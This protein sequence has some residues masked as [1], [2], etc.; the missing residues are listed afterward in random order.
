MLKIKKSQRDGTY[1]VY[2]PDNFT[3]HTHCKS[4]RVALVIRSNVEKGRLPKSNDLRMLYSQLRLTKNRQY[5]KLLEAKIEESEE[6]RTRRKT[7]L[8]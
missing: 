7:V 8:F 3:L 6:T 2:N 4:L 5:R 1:I